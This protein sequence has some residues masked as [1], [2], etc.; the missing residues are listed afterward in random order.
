M[1][2]AIYVKDTESQL[3]RLQRHVLQQH[4]AVH[5]CV[6]RDSGQASERAALQKLRVSASHRDFPSRTGVGTGQLRAGELG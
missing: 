1:R 6:E 2:F 3:A 4:H 5:R